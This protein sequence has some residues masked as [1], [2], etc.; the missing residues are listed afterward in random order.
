MILFTCDI[1]WAPEEVI[2]DT[3][4]F[5]SSYQVSLTLFATHDSKVLQ[6]A[7]TSLF[8]IGI[9]PNFNPLLQNKVE[10]PQTSSPDIISEL[11]LIYPQAKGVRSHS[12]T[13]ST[14]LLD[15]F[16]NAGLL[17]DA[18][19]FLPYQSVVPY[20]L[21]NGLFRIPYNWEDDIHWEYGYDF[22][23]GF[24]LNSSN[25]QL[26]ILDFHPI[27]L[28]INT[29]SAKQYAEAKAFYQQPAELMKHRNIESK[30]VRTFIKEVLDHLTN[31]GQSALTISEFIH[32]N[33]F[34]SRT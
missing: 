7:D 12:M 11:L 3:I 1:D 33:P 8:E 16:K 15:Q 34:R 14:I 17:Y 4:D 30:G 21:W 22:E 6:K 13:Q 24:I 25:I 9:H 23:P 19:H 5:F 31:T 18:N 2:Q 32:Q 20:T 27:H 26:W 28:F 10:N 29:K